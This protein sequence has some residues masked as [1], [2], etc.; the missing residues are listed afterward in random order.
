[1]HLMRGPVIW[2]TKGLRA[3]SPV[4]VTS[5]PSPSAASSLSSALLPCV[6]PVHHHVTD[7][8]CALGR[9]KKG[10][11]R[12]NSAEET[13]VGRVATTPLQKERLLER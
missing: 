7:L 1:M 4:A 9:T 5:S 10:R 11:C 3:A 6:A 2:T 8:P 12:T 13:R